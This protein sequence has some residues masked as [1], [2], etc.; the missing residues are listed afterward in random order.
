MSGKLGVVI[1]LL[2]GFLLTG[3]ASLVGLKMARSEFDER[4]KA[5][6]ESAY[7]KG[8]QE[9][10]KTAASLLDEAALEKLREENAA[11]KRRIQELEKK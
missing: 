9:G 1:G 8:L 2:G 7:F 6:K 10:T 11:L 5:E 3:A 4:V